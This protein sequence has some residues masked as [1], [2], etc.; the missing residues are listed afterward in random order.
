MQT[1]CKAFI[2]II[3]DTRR[4]LKGTATFPVKLRVTFLSILPTGKRHTQKYF[5]TGFNLTVEDFQKIKGSPRSED[6]KL[7]KGELAK[8]EQKAIAVCDRYEVITPAVFAADFLNYGSY[9][10]V[11]DLFSVYESRLHTQNRFGSE[12]A[13]RNALAS[14]K[15]YS[16]KSDILFGELTPEWL[17]EYERWMIERGRSI[18]TVGIYLRCL[19][20]IYKQAV[21]DRII[22][23]ELY[24]FGSKRYQIP[25]SRAF[26]RALTEAQKDFILLY[27]TADAGRREALDFWMLSYFCYG[28]NIKDI[29]CLTWDKIVDD[30]MLVERAKTAVTERDKTVISIP[31]SDEVKDIIRR[32]GVRSLNPRGFVFPILEHGISAL[33]KFHRVKSFIKRC[34][35]ELRLVG[36]EMGLSFSLTTYSA[37]HTFATVMKNRG[38]PLRFIKEAL[39]HNSEATTESYLSSFMTEDKI[40]FAEV[41][42]AK[43]QA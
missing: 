42:K 6:L 43:K 16:G 29:L 24:P 31:I 11:S 40:K 21:S 34:N 33:T 32:H 20:A 13:Y 10:T 14:L 26:K 1:Q 2:A 41:L 5:P 27:E 39:G 38:V 18:S 3:H 37:R 7:I 8:I 12:C 22:G 15:A 19:R 35:K 25:T 30:V 17:R 9:R 28:L 36:E 23:G 4:A